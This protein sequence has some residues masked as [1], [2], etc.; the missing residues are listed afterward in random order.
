[1]ADA[2]PRGKWIDLVDPDEA[3]L[4]P[5]LEHDI[6]GGALEQLLAPTEHEDEPRPKLE[7]HGTY[8]FGVFLVMRTIPERDLI[9]HQEIDLVLTRER[10]LTVRKT[11]EHGEP[12]DLS[13]IL[14]ADRTGRLGV[15]LIAAE[16]ADDVAEAY[17]DLLDAIHDEIDELEDQVES[18]ASKT[19]QRRISDLRHDLL[20]VRRTLAPT[21]DAVRRVVDDRVELDIEG[22]KETLEELFPRQVELR[23]GDVYDKLLRATDGLETAR[24]L[25]S[26]V[27]D[28]LQAK[29]ANDQNEVMKRLTVVASLLLLPTFIVGLYGQNFHDIPELS[30]SQG[31]GF[32]WALIVVT[33]V[34]QLAYFRWKRWI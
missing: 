12:F 32:S 10:V 8:V 15:G 6:Y 24:D 1:M 27:R 4:R 31:Y 22:G 23:F 14:E 13:D 25:I 17:L 33:T 5:Y 19:V 11:P 21:R 16:I 3:T 26:G 2:P 20:H 30:W 18:A 28:Y 29:V 34:A 7:S 9:Y